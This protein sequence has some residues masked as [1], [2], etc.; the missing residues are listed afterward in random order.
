MAITITTDLAAN[1]AAY[2]PCPLAGT[3]DRW[4]FTGTTRKTANIDAMGSNGGKLSLEI[5]SNTGWEIGDTVKISG[6][7]GDFEQ[8]NGLHT[9]LSKETT[10]YIT[11]DTTWVAASTGTEG[12]V[13][14]MND[15]LYIKAEVEDQTTG[16]IVA[17]LYA[18]VTT[19]GA[20]E[21]DMAKALQ[22]SLGSSFDLT[23]GELDVTAMVRE[24]AID[25]T[26]VYQDTDY[27]TKE[28]SDT[29]T[30]TFAHRMT[31][32]AAS[33]V[34]G[35]S[36]LQ[37]SSWGYDKIVLHFLT[38]KTS[39]VRIKVTTSSGYN[40][41][42]SITTFSDQHCGYVID[43]PAVSDVIGTAS[44]YVYVTVQH[45]DGGGYDDI[46]ETILIKRIND[47]S[48]TLLYF[49]NRLGGY[50]AY[51][52]TD[53]DDDQR[54]VK[55][56]KYTAETWQE[57]K[58]VGQQYPKGEYQQIRDVITSPEV[59]DI[60]GAL[61]RVLTDSVNYRSQEVNPQI[62]IRYDETFINA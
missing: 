39:S 61:V 59:Y 3:T 4:P 37:G 25:L 30:S 16:D 54:T 19:G 29:S 41:Y 14:R 7:T 60:D 24:Y 52:F 42:Y 56:D 17:E 26:E 43:W 2:A 20:W 8:Y 51:K 10:D 38:D 62:T 58:L 36:L 49:V 53:Y 46:K 33:Y 55:V 22:V 34:S 28:G 32:Y 5:V 21:F 40:W 27:T 9:V 13:F 11:L 18:K 1:V 31:E 50:E 15:N 47:C 45:D 6:A 57:R 44:P 23:A 48:D 35:T 12:T